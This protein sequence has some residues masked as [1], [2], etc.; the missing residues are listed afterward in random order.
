MSVASPA[1]ASGDG[2]GRLG[3]CS[4]ADTL[5]LGG[6]SALGLDCALGGGACCD[7]LIADRLG[8]PFGMLGKP[9]IEP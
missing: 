8:K 3:S 7:D 2:S 4:G 1:G 9:G 6:F 5:A